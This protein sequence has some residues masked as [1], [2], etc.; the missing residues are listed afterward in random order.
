V[1]EIPIP[2]LSGDAAEPMTVERQRTMQRRM[3]SLPT[4]PWQY[5]GR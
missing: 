2:K 1:E 5:D 3:P 4:M